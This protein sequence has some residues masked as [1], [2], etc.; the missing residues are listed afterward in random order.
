MLS[1][2]SRTPGS[3]A[4]EWPM[5]RRSHIEPHPGGYWLQTHTF[6][7]HLISFPHTCIS[8]HRW[9]QRCFHSKGRY[10]HVLIKAQKKGKVVASSPIRL[11]HQQPS[12]GTPSPRKWVSSQQCQP[13]RQSVCAA[14]FPAQAPHH[15]PIR[16]SQHPG[17]ASPWPEMLLTRKTVMV[18]GRRRPHSWLGM[19]SSLPDPCHHKNCCFSNFW[20]QQEIHNKMH[21]IKS[22]FPC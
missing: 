22:L 19:V 14:S 6:P 15:M 2:R 17:P 18:M 10:Q 7:Q 8:T 12:D 5:L 16:P 4:R 11:K 21:R 3:T 9:H 20:V 13:H 1:S